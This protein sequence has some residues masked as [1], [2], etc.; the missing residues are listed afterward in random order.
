ME[1]SR[2][3]FDLEDLAA[4][5][6]IPPGTLRKWRS[7]GKGPPAVKLGKHLRFRIEDVEAWLASQPSDREAT[8]V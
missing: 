8:S 3:C 7:A 2:Q 6:R 5:L 1:H 4:Y